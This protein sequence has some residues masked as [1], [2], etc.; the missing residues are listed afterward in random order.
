MTPSLSIVV[1]CY[2]EE[3][4]LPRCIAALDRYVAS[5]PRG[6]IEVVL[7]DDGSVDGTWSVLEHAVR[8][9]DGW[10]AIHLISNRG[11][12]IALRCAYRHA[13]GEHV[14]NLPVDLQEP[15]ENI[16]R[17]QAAR[18]EQGADAVLAVRRSRDDGW[19]IRVT[20]RAYNTVMHLVG[21]KNLLH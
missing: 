8:D 9:R 19:W 11:S 13:A 20:S 12:H 21:L 18:D 17:L 15:I 3:L 14:V 7:V 4:E 10:R 16:D 1:A 6:S 2:N 5:K